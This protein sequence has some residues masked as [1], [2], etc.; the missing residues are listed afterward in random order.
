M[1]L[2]KLTSKIHTEVNTSKKIKSNKKIENTESKSNSEDEDYLKKKYENK[3]REEMD[4][5]SPRPPDISS[6]IN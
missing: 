6:N 5:Q 1:M 4:V 3:T 2:W